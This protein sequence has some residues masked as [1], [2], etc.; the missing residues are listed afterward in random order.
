MHNLARKAYS[1]VTSRTATD[2]Q[3]EYALFSDIT[4]A[5]KDVAAQDMPPPAVWAEAIDRN[6]Q[7]WLALS[8]D[9]LNPDNRLDPQL[10]RGLLN[11]GEM[12]RRISHRVLSGETDLTEIIE[13][14]EA[15]MAGLSGDPGSG[16]AGVAA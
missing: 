9:L 10:R 8:V 7:L 3:I 5:L 15:I 16:L 14:N 11:L 6:L 13:I 12:V 1:D 2:K 4:N